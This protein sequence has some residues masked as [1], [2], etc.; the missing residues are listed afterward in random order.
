MGFELGRVVN[1]AAEWASGPG[2]LGAVVRNPLLVA[3][4]LTALALAVVYAVCGGSL[5]GGLPRR[6]GWRQAARA[7]VYIFLG[8]SA[9]L[10]LH[11]YAADRAARTEAGRQG[12]RDVVEATYT[13]GGNA[14]DSVPIRPRDTMV[15]GT[16]LR[17]YAPPAAAT[18]GALA[19]T[20]G[21]AWPEWRAP[22]AGDPNPNCACGGD[23]AAATTADPS[24]LLGLRP[25]PPGVPMGAGQP[26]TA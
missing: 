25:M 22:G 10:F 6:P 20:D 12:Y 21:W 3:L 15:G 2:A 8:A 24:A 13:L 19:S 26:R 4:L 7:G 14:V 9:L 16:I 1:G 23:D 18:G 17:T 11:F 5:S